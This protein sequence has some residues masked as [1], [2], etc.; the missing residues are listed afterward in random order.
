HQSIDIGGGPGPQHRRA[1]PDRV[2]LEHFEPRV[3][4]VER[5]LTNGARGFAGSLD[6]AELAQRI[7]SRRNELA[8]E[9]P[10]IDL[11]LLVMEARACAFL[12]MNRRDLHQAS[13]AST[14]A[15]CSTR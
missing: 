4:I 3:E 5:A 13:P 7:A 2:R 12:E 11:K 8:L 9:L 6:V 1:R 14:S 15:T 10:Q